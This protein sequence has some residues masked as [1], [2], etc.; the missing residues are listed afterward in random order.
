MFPKGNLISLE[1][2]ILAPYAKSIS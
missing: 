1:P 2:F